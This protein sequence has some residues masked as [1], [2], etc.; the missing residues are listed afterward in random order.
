MT[1]RGTPGIGTF[2]DSKIP[3]SGVRRHPQHKPVANGDAGEVRNTMPVTDHTNECNQARGQREDLGKR[4]LLP[5]L[6]QQQKREGY[7]RQRQRSIERKATGSTSQSPVAHTMSKKTR[8][9]LKSNSVAYSTSV[10]QLKTNTTAAQ[11]FPKN[12]SLAALPFSRC[13]H[14]DSPTRMKHRAAFG[15]MNAVSGKGVFRN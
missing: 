10:K 14:R 7:W 2:F 9:I 4:L 15:A 3:Y 11:I 5:I 12:L 13:H 6:I 8:S 1:G